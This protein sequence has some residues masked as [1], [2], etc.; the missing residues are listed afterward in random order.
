MIEAA[1]FAARYGRWA[2]VIGGSDG[3]GADLARD[4]A[5]RGVHCVLVARRLD[6]LDG[7]AAELRAET[8]VEVR[9]ASIDIAQPDAVEKLLGVV[10]DIDLGLVVFNAGADSSGSTF[11]GSSLAM[12]QDIVRRNVTVLTDSLY[13][14]ADRFVRQ[15]RGG[16]LIVGS[17]AAFGGGARA[18]IYTATKGYALNLGE[19]LWAE[20]KPH[21]VDVL[22]LCFLVGDTPVLRSALAR[23]AIPVEAVG[24]ASTVDLARAAL[25]ALPDGPMLNYDEDPS[26][27]SPLSSAAARRE[28]VL[29]VSAGLA[30][31]Y[32]APDAV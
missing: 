22:T 3:L 26:A 1:S 13:H 19:S 32:G 18:G 16:L 29:Q 31:F 2:L 21:G 4:I 10:D 25:D 15:R 14:F 23:N 20:L 27:P 7:L 24:A 5:R 17:A 12:W 6:V 30:Q 9:T 28:H 11:L 8:G